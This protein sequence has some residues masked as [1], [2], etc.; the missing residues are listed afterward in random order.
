MNFYEALVECMDARGVS[1][2][3]LCER[4]GYYPSYF[5]KLKSG[6][7]KDVTWERAVAII[8]AL[9]MTPAEFLDVQ[10]SR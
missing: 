3:D 4:T 5:S 2:T 7:A 6:H 1:F 10:R 8:T 9:G